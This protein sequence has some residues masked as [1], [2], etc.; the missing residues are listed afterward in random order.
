MQDLGINDGTHEYM[1]AFKNI[2]FL[3]DVQKNKTAKKMSKL[4]YYQ[5]THELLTPINTMVSMV[6]V[7]KIKL[8]GADSD[9]I[10]YI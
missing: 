2:T 1:F 9:I 3:R 6:E 10:D 4:A 7:I 5:V 8:V